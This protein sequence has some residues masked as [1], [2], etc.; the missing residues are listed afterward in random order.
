M[1]TVSIA[2]FGAKTDGSLSTRAIQDAIDY[3]F[4]RGGGTVE[5]PAGVYVTGGVRLRSNITLLLRSGACL[6]GTRNPQDYLAFL[7]D[8]VEPVAQED[9][10][11]Q[12]WTCATDYADYEFLRRP[13][14]RWNNG[15]IRAIDA[16]NIAI[17]GEPGAVIDGSDC[18][19]EMGEE[20]YRGPHG[21]NMHRCRK[22]HFS[23]YTIQNTGNWAHAL[24][25]CQDIHAEQVTMLAGHDGIHLTSCDRALIE[26]CQ[27]YTGD[28]CIA[29]IDNRDVQVQ[30]CILNTACSA[31]RFGGQNVRIERCKMF[32]PARYL[33]RGSLSTEEKRLGKPPVPRPGHRFN[34]LSAFTYYADFSRQIRGRQGDILM[35]DCDVD[36]VDRFIHYNYSGNE[37][38]QRNRPLEQI[39]FENVRVTGLRMPLTLYGDP[40]KKISC[41]IRHCSFS[42]DEAAQP[43]FMKLCHYAKVCLEDVTIRGCSDPRIQRWSDDGPVACR[44][45]DCDP[46]LQIEQAEEPFECKP[47]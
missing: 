15:L 20:H 34:M 38:W 1:E 43:A 47:I 31:F 29:G 39:S 41:E 9:L 13:A 11:Q 36:Q 25:E 40:E 6:K 19:D 33:F 2:A 18:Y 42:F 28:D 46:P 35:R 37:L 7:N 14:S 10:C 27:C 8:P 16:E 21:V 17:I 4:A 3:C 26:H 30:D 32:G 24:F 12:P 44:E 5:I 23:G 45:V 22:L